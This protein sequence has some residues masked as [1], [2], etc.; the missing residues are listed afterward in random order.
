MNYE[1]PDQMPLELK[2]DY[3]PDDG[4]YAFVSWRWVMPFARWIGKRKCLEVM[5]GRG[6]LSFALHKLGTNV[7]ATDD[8]SWGLSGNVTTIE[9]L[10]ALSA[11]KIYGRHTDILLMSWPPATDMAYHVLHA[12][13]EVNSD[14]QLVYIGEC[15]GGDMASELFFQHFEPVFDPLFEEVADA[16]ESR[17]G[18]YDKP[19]LGRYQVEAKNMAK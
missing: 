13:H 19:M 14:G 15:M 3:Q 7:I 12:Y 9:S 1:V 11:I 6:M 17:F 5:A 8:F 4:Q 18:Y 16:Y 10:D 2:T